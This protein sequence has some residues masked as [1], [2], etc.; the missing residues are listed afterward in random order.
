MVSTGIRRGEDGFDPG[1]VACWEDSDVPSSGADNAAAIVGGGDGGA[2][3]TA[4]GVGGATGVGGIVMEDP[5][6]PRDVVGLCG[7]PC[8]IGSLA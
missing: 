6:S 2:V 5:F 7:C 8:V 1:A 4:I 3:R